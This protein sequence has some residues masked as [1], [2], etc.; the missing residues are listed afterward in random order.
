MS[1]HA[2][3]R[4]GRNDPGRHPIPRSSGPRCAGRE[5][6]HVA[7]AS[8]GGRPCLLRMGH[9]DASR[10]GCE[11]RSP[12]LTESYE[13]YV[14]AIDA[15]RATID[16]SPFVRDDADRSTRAPVPSHRRELVPRHGAQ[17]RSRASDDAVAPGPGDA[18][19]ST[20]PT[21]SITSRASP[22]PGRIESSG[23]AGT[24]IG[25]LILALQELPGNG[26]GSGVTTA[27]LTGDDLDARPP[28]ARTRS[29]SAPSDLRAATGSRSLR[30]PTTCSSG[31]RSRTGHASSGAPLRSNDSTL[32]TPVAARMTHDDAA[33][34]L[35]DAARSIELQAQFYRDQG[36]LW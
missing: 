10:A 11:R 30:E 27:F 22:T 5:R 12:V 9:D 33:A 35:D 4:R 2:T 29:R 17:P 7:C 23:N 14:A 3:D 18:S 24:S 15:A 31:S 13:R 19:G 6:R 20:T 32:P 34:V 8:E 25:F 16:T 36:A 26:D 28:T 21:T 1:G